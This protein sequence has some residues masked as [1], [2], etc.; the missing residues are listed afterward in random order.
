M[1]ENEQHTRKLKNIEAKG[2]EH[3]RTIDGNRGERERKC[4]NMNEHEPKQTKVNGHK[5][6]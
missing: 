3:G 2:N 1:D 4:T 5:Q 6:T